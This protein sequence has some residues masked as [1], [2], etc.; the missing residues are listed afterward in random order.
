MTMTSIEPA[1]R[2][3]TG[4]ADDPEYDRFMERARVREERVGVSRV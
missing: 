3:L 1:R 4:N 2:G